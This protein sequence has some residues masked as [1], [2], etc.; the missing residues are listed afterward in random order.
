MTDV[1]DECPAMS[2]PART[3]G[4]PTRSSSSATGRAATI[5]FLGG[6]GTVTGSRHLVRTD[7]ARVLVD[8]GLFQGLR[9]LRNRNWDDPPF[10]PAS[11]DA[12]VVTHAHV[13][14]C[15]YLPRLVAAGYRGPIYATPTTIDLARIVLPDCGHLQEEEA[16]YA[17]RKG[18][19]RHE[20]A[21]PLYTEDDAWE[22]VGQLRAAPFHTDLEIAPGVTIRMS[23]AGHILGAASVSLRLGRDGPVVGVGGDLGRSSHPFLVPPDPPGSVDCLLVE[24]TYGDREHDDTDATDELG[25][26]IRTTIGRGGNVLIPAFAVDRTEVLLHHL[27][28]LSANAQLPDGVPIFVDSPMALNALRVYRAAIER[29]DPD[30]RTDVSGGTDPFS[31][32]GLHE[33]IDVEGSKAL[34]NP[35]QPSIIISASGMATGGRVVHHLAHLLPQPA[36]TILL[37]GFQAEGTRG[38][39]LLEGARELKML[40]RYVRV[41][42]SVVDLPNFSVHADGTELLAWVASAT[43]PPDTVYVVHGEPAASRALAAAISGTLGWNAVVPHHGEVVRLDALD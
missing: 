3:A 13:D 33:V 9:D 18:F 14:H 28:Q 42:A 37:V 31:V 41:G 27:A 21:L 43:R 40:G 36:N 32:P 11:L 24:S 17:N 6:T 26:I 12:V 15:G 34:N 19:S 5:Q 38:R 25:K 2:G 20:P 29:G 7:D 39:R 10:D 30:V 16:E 1:D 23:R 22:A 35:A 4:Q 8:C